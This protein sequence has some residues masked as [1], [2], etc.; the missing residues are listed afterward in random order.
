MQE[1]KMTIL[2]MVDDGKITADDAVKLL[3]AMGGSDR[4]SAVK[5]KVTALSQNARPIVKKAAN[6]AKHVAGGV[7]DGAKKSADIISSRV[8]EIKN[9]P[10]KADFDNDVVAEPVGE[11]AEDITDKVEIVEEKVKDVA[12]DIKDKAEDV[13]EKIKDKAEDIK[14]KAEDAAE[15][16]KEEME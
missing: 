2:K 4:L 11:A 8:T 1:E 3:K 15:A 13:A 9:K 7:A 12:E 6:V 10:R 14:D 16:V 5:E